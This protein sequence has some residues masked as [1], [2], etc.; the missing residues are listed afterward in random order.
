M[1]YGSGIEFMGCM[2]CISRLHPPTQ[3]VDIKEG[4][5]DVR[6]G[7]TQT[8]TSYNTALI[9]KVS[10]AGSAPK[11]VNI[12]FRKVKYFIC[13]CSFVMWRLQFGVKFTD[14]RWM[15]DILFDG[16]LR[17]VNDQAGRRCWITAG[18]LQ[19]SESGYEIKFCWRDKMTKKEGI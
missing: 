4:R 1:F 7:V 6:F 8:N 13:P 18:W 3:T 19:N 9:S 2:G 10:A 16:L 17:K 15:K 14:E 5:G 12:F 11:Y